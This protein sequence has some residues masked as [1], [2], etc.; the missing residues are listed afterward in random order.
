MHCIMCSF[1]AISGSGFKNRCCS[2]LADRDCRV[3]DESRVFRKVEP[4]SPACL[5]ACR[6]RHAVGVTRVEVDAV[7]SRR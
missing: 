2:L 3:V 5:L 1:G 7:E 4:L 6:F